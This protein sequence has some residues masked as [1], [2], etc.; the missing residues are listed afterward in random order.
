MEMLAGP[1]GVRRVAVAA[2]LLLAPL[3]HNLR[4]LALVLLITWPVFFA[5]FVLFYSLLCP[6]AHLPLVQP[7]VEL[8]APVCGAWQGLSGAQLRDKRHPSI[9]TAAQLPQVGLAQ[10]GQT[11]Q[12]Y[13]NRWPNRS[14]PS[15]RRH[16]CASPQSDPAKHRD[17]R[18]NRVLAGSV[19]K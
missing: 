10:S 2:G 1:M 4:T 13:R 5:S 6:S 3:G 15:A 19:P 8:F 18:G 14:T 16:V 17:C 11:S 12:A 7:F 9:A